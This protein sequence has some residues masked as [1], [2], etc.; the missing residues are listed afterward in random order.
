MIPIF[1][2]VIENKGSNASEIYSPKPPGEGGF[3]LTGLFIF[4]AFKGEVRVNL[5][6]RLVC[7]GE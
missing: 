3:Q 5:T 2:E 6:T 4:T 7:T 1:A